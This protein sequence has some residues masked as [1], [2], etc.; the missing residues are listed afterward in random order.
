MGKVLVTDTYLS[1]IANAIRGKNGTNNTYTPAQM[2]TAIQNIQPTLKL[3]VIRP[4]AELIKTYTY[5]KYI[6]EDESVTIPSYTTSSTSL[7]ATENLETVSFNNADYYCCIVLRGLSIPVYPSGTT[8]GKGMPLFGIASQIYEIDS[9][10]ATTIQG[11][12]LQ[13]Y[14][15]GVNSAPGNFIIYWS[16]GTA[17]ARTF[18]NYGVYMTPQTPSLSASGTTITITPKSPILYVRGS[19][20]YF[21]STYFDAITD[22]RY[23]YIMEVYRIPKVSGLNYDG[24]GH[25]TL[26][27]KALDCYLNNNGTLT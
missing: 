25:S 12:T 20:S 4:D 22:I 16:S 27:K 5:D 8:P 15:S 11:L 6:H 2:A 17:L 19:T 23:Q 21:T 18:T 14:Y 10:V 3:G 24:W 26:L 13:P 1:N 7:K 9:S